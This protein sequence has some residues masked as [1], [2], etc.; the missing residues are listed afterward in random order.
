MSLWCEAGTERGPVTVT[1][2]PRPCPQGG[3]RGRGRGR[4]QQ[5]CIPCP[6]GEGNRTRQSG[7]PLPATW[8]RPGYMLFRV[9]PCPMRCDHLHGDSLGL[10][11]SSVQYP[12]WLW[13]GSRGRYHLEQALL[14]GGC[15]PGRGPGRWGYRQSRSSSRTST[16]PPCTAAAA[17]MMGLTR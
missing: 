10:L 11:L 5:R 13:Q 3:G 15:N 2:T 16:K 6:S 17:A 9:G 1:P 4:G 8:Q 14:A 12:G 7:S